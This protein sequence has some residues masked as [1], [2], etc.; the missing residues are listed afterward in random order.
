MD[1]VKRLAD[2][3]KLINGLVGDWLEF[4]TSYQL[5]SYAYQDGGVPLL[6]CKL[7]LHS[8]RSLRATQLSTLLQ[9]CLCAHFCTLVRLFA[10]TPWY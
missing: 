4:D 1:E 5:R 8:S 3:G 7:K 2:A 6:S 10:D 9:A